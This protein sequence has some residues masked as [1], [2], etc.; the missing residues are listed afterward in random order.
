MRFRKSDRFHLH[1]PCAA[2]SLALMLATSAVA[3]PPMDATRQYG[4]SQAG[5]SRGNGFDEGGYVQGTPLPWSELNPTQRSMF[6][7]LREQWNQLPPRR[8][9]R[10]AAHAEQWMQLPPE[11]RE[12]IQRRL[13]RWAKMTP[14]Q[15]RNAAQ[16]ERTFQAMPNADRQ[17]VLE[18]YQ[19]FQ[20]L[21]PEQ[22][23]ML[24]QRFRQQREAH[25]GVDGPGR[26]RSQR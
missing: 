19:R 6:A 21:S 2:M 20:A 1:F 7:P 22:R 9:Q 24:M 10:M 8:Q 3:S 17:R 13:V 16:G 4:D 14:E 12:Q 18:A 5:E 11:R 23:R 15:R 26:S 25:H